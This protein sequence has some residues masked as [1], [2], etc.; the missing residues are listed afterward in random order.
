MVVVFWVLTTITNRHFTLD[1]TTR[2][3]QDGIKHTTLELMRLT[4]EDIKNRDRDLIEQK[5]ASKQ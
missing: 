5:A 2:I 4:R 3:D 1:K